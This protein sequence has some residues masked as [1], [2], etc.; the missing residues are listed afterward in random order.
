MIITC[1]YCI[2]RLTQPKVKF[3]N[4]DYHLTCYLKKDG[5]KKLTK[6][7]LND[8][9]RRLERMSEICANALDNKSNPEERKKKF[10]LIK[11]KYV[12]LT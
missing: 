9:V 12:D 8:I 7:V 5:S 2:K 3:H 11:T 4:K 6:P 1:I 10:D